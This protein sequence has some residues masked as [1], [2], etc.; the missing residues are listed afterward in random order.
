MLVLSLAAVALAAFVMTRSAR[1]QGGGDN[2]MSALA[3][4][5]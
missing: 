3:G 2:A 1:R 5:S 4:L